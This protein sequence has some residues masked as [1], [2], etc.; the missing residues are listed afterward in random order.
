MAAPPEQNPN[1]LPNQSGQLTASASRLRLGFGGQALRRN[2]RA[3]RNS[4]P[5]TPLPPR[6]RLADSFL[7]AS[8]AR[9]H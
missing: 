3:R 4:P 8:R 2:A 1:F 6:P 9:R 5:H 7:P